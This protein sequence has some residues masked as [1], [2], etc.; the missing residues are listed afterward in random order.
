VTL[1]I[2]AS[3]NKAA[4]AKPSGPAP[5]TG[6]ESLVEQVVDELTAWNPREFITAFQ[7][8]HQGAIS[9]VHLNVLT[10]LEASGPMSMGRL[11]ESLDIS[12]ASM[13]G[14]IDRMEARGLVQRRRDADDRRVILV[15]PAAGGRRLFENI[16]K[17]RRKGLALLLTKLNER[18]LQGLLVGHRALR[19]A[20]L[21]LIQRTAADTAQAELAKAAG[22]RVDVARTAIARAAAKGAAKTAAPRA[23]TSRPEQAR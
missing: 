20:R 5:K 16:G 10:M 23:A 7:R 11:S 19:E 6:K 17:R 2:S 22:R 9:L 12:V 1:N 15:H 18:E 4:A 3:Q 8:W 13:T 14:V 21:G